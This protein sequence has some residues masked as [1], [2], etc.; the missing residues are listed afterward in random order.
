MAVAD[1]NL[2][3]SDGAPSDWIEISNGGPETVDLEGFHLTNNRDDLVRWSFPDSELAPGSS[4]IVFASGKNRTTGGELHTNFTLD[5]GGDYLALIA[6]DGITIVSEI[7]AGYPEQFEGISYGIGTAGAEQREVPIPRGAP[8]KLHIPSDASLGDDWTQAGFDD[9]GW[10][11]A[12]AGVGFEARGGTLEPLVATDIRSEMI[13]KNASAYLRFPF[14]FDLADRQVL[15]MTLGVNVDDG[16][17][18]YLNGV[19]V[20]SFGKPTPLTWESQSDAKRSDATVVSTPITIPISG[21]G[22]ALVS[23][24]NVLAIHG[25]NESVGSSDFL[26]DAKLDITTLSTSEGLQFG[27]FETPTPD[28][29]NDRIAL[30]PPADVDFSETG[31]MFSV[32][33]AL[34]LSCAT[35]GAVI[36]YTTDLSV[37]TETS[38]EYTAP[39]PITESVQIRARAFLPGALDGAVTTQTYLRMAGDVAAFS[40]DLPVIVVSTLGTGSPPGTSSTLRRNSYMFFFEPDPASGR[41]T[42]TQAPVIATRAGV[43]R[44]GSSSSIWPKYSMSVETWQDGNDDDRNITPFA[45]PREADWILNARYEWDLALMRNPF[46]YEISRQIGRYAPR[47][48]FVEV[49]SDTTGAEVSGSDYFGVYSLIERIEVDPNRVD[50]DKLMP[51]ENALP[52]ISGGYIFKNDRPD[53]GEPTMS[54]GGMGQLTNVDPDGLELSSQQRSW[55]IGHLNELNT[56]LTNTPT[57]INP[58]T[59]LGIE[60]YVDIDSWI[61]HHLLNLLVMNIDWG[62]HSAFFYKDRD[63]KIVSGP[64]WDYDRA[65]GC[66]DVRDNEPRAWEGVVNAVGTVS[67]KTWFDSRF[68]WYGNLLGPTADPAEA[69]YPDI[70]QR[71]TDRWFELRRREFSIDHLHAVIDSLADEIRES[72]VRNFVRWTQYPANG[73]NFAEPGL[74]GWEAEVSHMKGWLATRAAWVDSQYLS[75]PAF[76]TSGGMVGEDFQLIVGSPDGQV[77]YTTDGTD[78]RA[79]G[80][81]PSA[82]ATGFPGGPVTDTLIDATSSCRYLVPVDGSLALTWTD[83][84]GSFDDSNWSAGT[85]GVGFESTG[86][87]S[88][89]IETDIQSEMRGS[90][91]SCY[92]RY[93]FEFDNAA[94]ITAITLSVQSDDGFVAYLNGEEAGRSLAPLVPDWNSTTE[95]GAGRPGGD[96]AVIN[97]PVVIDLTSLKNRVHNGLNVIAIHGLNSSAGGSDF[98]VRPS[99]D[100]THIVTPSPL[101]INTSQTITARTF[102]GSTWSA[103]ESVTLILSEEGAS[104]ENLVVSEIMYHP[105]DPSPEEVAAGHGDANLF[106]YLEILNIGGGPVTLLGMEFSA[107]LSFDFSQSLIQPLQ[108]GERALLVRDRAAFEFRYGVAAAGRI[109]GEF[110]NGTGLDNGGERLALT[111]VGGSTV[112]DFTYNDRSPWPIAADGDGYSLVLVDPTLAPD[113]NIATNWRS[114]ATHGG[115]P[116]SSDSIGFADW[117]AGFGNPAAGSDLDSDG[118]VALLEFASG[119]DPTSAN[120]S[121]GAVRISLDAGAGAGAGE[122]VAVSFR[123][124]LRADGILFQLEASG[125]LLNWE[126][127]DDRWLPA[128]EQNLGDGTAMVSFVASGDEIKLYLRQR[129]SQ[130]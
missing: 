60:D 123:R 51:W 5:R 44:R 129:I 34:A 64:V 112:R 83:S 9:S 56:A 29:P 128:G 103:P 10:I 116:G 69:N 43:R 2:R 97:T 57:G 31:R 24:A 107:G 87:I 79:P 27:Y 114:S 16:F 82:T 21:F 49:F 32:P 8:L 12:T 62:R 48:Q 84:P 4:M 72:Q 68:P 63:D 11:S 85:G 115:T 46:V 65:L 99:L 95:G 81:A 98:L 36:R 7:A 20:G 120:P 58:S 113:H 61:D 124:N 47:T 59:G 86:G 42:L 119:D 88:D 26:V 130:R 93:P 75:P 125:D 55:L 110:A 45:M 28:A 73:G 41:T 127:A 94:S 15:S 71:H 13:G 19:E 101:A 109:A 35:P 39:I 111:G 108:A 38:S 102:D 77:Y 121:G 100:V 126:P 14:S 37:P 117:A 30:P 17:V 96:T 18:A 40:S 74:V 70:R 92:L 104:A 106:E 23:G 22:A 76:N 3:D 33:S 89:L 105:A 50:I 80:G 78:P 6:P 67:S 54:V 53:P 122:R 118:Y 90:N 1:V 66:E 25:M 91:A 52:E